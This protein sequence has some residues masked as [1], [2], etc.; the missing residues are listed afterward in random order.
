MLKIEQSAFSDC[1]SL[2]AIHVEANNPFFSSD[3]GVLFNKNK[4]KLLCYPGGHPLEYFTILNSTITIETYAFY[5]A[6]KLKTVLIPNSVAHIGSQA[7]IECDSLQAVKSKMIKPATLSPVTFNGNPYHRLA[8]KLYV[9]FG[10]KAAYEADAEWNVFSEIIES[11]FT[12]VSEISDDNKS[13]IIVEA[14]GCIRITGQSVPAQ[15]R[16]YSLTGKVFFDKKVI[17][18]EQVILE[19]FPSGVYIVNLINGMSNISEK[20]IL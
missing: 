6:R 13:S 1:N 17:E 4:T 12:S 18:D 16:I 20:V 10:T 7:F 14:N 11:D 2:T 9:P 15:V 19:E 5:G 3:S 8:G